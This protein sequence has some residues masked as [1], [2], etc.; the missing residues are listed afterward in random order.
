MRLAS[1]YQQPKSAAYVPPPPIPIHPEGKGNFPLQKSSSVIVKDLT[2]KQLIEHITA[3]YTSKIK[4]DVLSAQAH[5]P[6]ETME[7]HLYNYLNKKYGLK[8]LIVSNASA[9]L[10]AIKRYSEEDTEVRICGKILRN[11]VDEE[12]RFMIAKLK[13][14]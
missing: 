3:L 9:I 12:F 14:L 10:K 13:V 1:N 2:V 7:Q 8:S 6:R 5:A 11:E 4:N